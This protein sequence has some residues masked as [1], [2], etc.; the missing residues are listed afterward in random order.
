MTQILT[1]NPHSN[2]TTAQYTACPKNPNSLTSVSK[3]ALPRSKSSLGS[4]VD[5]ES[6]SILGGSVANEVSGAAS[7]NAIVGS[8][9]GG[10]QVC[11][12]CWPEYPKQATCRRGVESVR[13]SFM[14]K[15]LGRTDVTERRGSWG[16]LVFS[17][18]EADELCVVETSV[19]DLLPLVVSS[20]AKWS[21]LGETV[22]LMLLVKELEVDDGMGSSSSSEV[23]EL[24]I[25]EPTLS[26]DCSLMRFRYMDEVSTFSRLGRLMSSSSCGTG[27][28]SSWLSTNRDSGLTYAGRAGS[29]FSG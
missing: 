14:S 19:S 3:L 27:V 11:C 9:A 23:K 12:C 21:C 29:S 6:K 5:K 2:Q 8:A 10:A 4:E 18:A 26:G 22:S 25:I 15:S 16:V 17:E 24:K 13:C 28:A 7:S 20:K 1:T